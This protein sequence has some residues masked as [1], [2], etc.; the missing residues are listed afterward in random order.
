MPSTNI[1]RELSTAVYTLL[2]CSSSLLSISANA[3]PHLQQAHSQQDSEPWKIN[4][5]LANY[6]E[7]DRNT[8]IELI[9]DGRREIDEDSLNIKFELDVIT[10]ATPNGATASDVPQTF[11]MSSGNGDYRVKANE[12]PADDTHMDT[13]FGLSTTYSKSF[14]LDLTVD[15]HSFISMEFDYL[16][17]GGGADI[18]HDFNQ[19]NTSLL[20]GINFEYNRVHPVGNIP[21]AFGIMQPAG[22][23][24]PRGKASIS[25]RVAGLSIGINQILTKQSLLQFKYSYAE[26]SGYLTDPYKILSLIGNPSGRT[27]NFLFENRPNERQIQSLYSAYKLFLSG[28]VLNLSYR[29]YWDEWDIRSNTFDIRYRKKLSDN[30]F[31]QPHLRYYTQTEADFF[32]HSLA[33]NQPLPKFASADFRLAEFDAYTIGIKYGKQTSEKNEHSISI[34]YYLQ[35]GESHPSD[36]IGLQKEQN[37]FPTLHTLILFYN[38]G[39]EW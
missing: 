29:Y 6:I 33:D 4:L 5:G 1:K 34:E 12:L 22:Q 30:N 17:F 28:D 38:Y 16:A 31:I 13:R 27:Q 26:A 10:G 32:T 14:N 39:F 25:R 24:Q 35:Q 19:S 2:G 3:D 18:K 9:I 11:T 15:Y 20:L 7:R 23:L 21:T 36:A 37:L 8:G